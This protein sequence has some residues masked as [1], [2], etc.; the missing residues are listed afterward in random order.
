MIF[1]HWTEKNH[2]NEDRIGFRHLLLVSSSGRSV[3]ESKSCNDDATAN[4]PASNTSD[5]RGSNTS[6]RACSM[7]DHR[8]R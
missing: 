3:R 8:F 2:L 6:H 7:V 5:T 4:V 1:F